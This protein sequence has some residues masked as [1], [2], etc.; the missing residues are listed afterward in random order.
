[1]LHSPGMEKQPPKITRRDVLRSV[2]VGS[3][4]GFMIPMQGDSYGNIVQAGE[5]QT[6]LRPYTEPPREDTTN[7]IPEYPLRKQVAVA[8]NSRINEISPAKSAFAVV[9]AGFVAGE[10]S[11]WRRLFQQEDADTMHPGEEEQVVLDM[12][13]GKLGNMSIHQ[14]HMARLLGVLAK[15]E[16]T[17]LSYIEEPDMYNAAIPSA[18]LRPPANSFQIATL[19]ASPYTAQSVSYIHGNQVHTEQQETY[20]LYDSMRQAGVETIYVAGEYSFN[21]WSKMSACLGGVAL[22]LMDEGFSV[23]GVQGAV[24]PTQ[25]QTGIERDSELAYALYDNA[26]PFH[27]A[28][29]IAHQ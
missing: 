13:S 10:L 2:V 28:L 5:L 6:A 14:G 18:R 23:R 3:A 17:I 19:E 27:Q 26:I 21:P 24:Y 20:R 22:D 15:S 7:Q 11:K 12:A 16:Q 8:A 29:Q 9:H 1:M 25:P 4:L